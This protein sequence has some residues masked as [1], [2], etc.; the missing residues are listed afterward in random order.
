[1]PQ[2]IPRRFPTRLAIG[3]LAALT[4]SPGCSAA[5]P[6]LSAADQQVLDAKDAW[7][8]RDR[9]RLQSARNALQQAH[10]SG[11]PD[12]AGSRATDAG[13]RQHPDPAGRNPQR[14]P[15]R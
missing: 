4:L 10:D 13:P 3:L 2:Q 12:P 8:A 9:N 7:R 1:M 5:P 6:P 14:R 11:N 15:R